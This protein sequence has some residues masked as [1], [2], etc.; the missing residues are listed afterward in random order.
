LTNA[1]ITAE[2]ERLAQRLRKLTD[3]PLDPDR[4]FE[5]R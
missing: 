4:L 1:E 2:P 5:D 3:A